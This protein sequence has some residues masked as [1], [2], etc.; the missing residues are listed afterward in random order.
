MIFKKITSKLYFSEQLKVIDFTRSECWNFTTWQFSPNWVK[1]RQRF[2]LGLPSA[3]SRV[4]LKC[5]CGGSSLKTLPI[6]RNKDI[7]KE[8]YCWK[9]SDSCSWRSQ[10]PRQLHSERII[11]ALCRDFWREKSARRH[12][13]SKPPRHSVQMSRPVVGNELHGDLRWAKRISCSPHFSSGVAVTR[14]FRRLAEAR[15]HAEL[16]KEHGWWRSGGSVMSAARGEGA[17][18]MTPPGVI[19]FSALLKK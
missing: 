1:P 14:R 18:R 16:I 8:S 3:A 19:L 4:R 9:K 10:R 6:N 5:W 2:S 15:L 7:K 12:S 13:K 17:S 11:M